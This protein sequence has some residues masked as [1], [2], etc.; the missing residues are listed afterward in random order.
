MATDD[1]GFTAP[2]RDAFFR[3]RG[4]D[5]NM[6][7]VRVPE[8]TT[9]GTAYAQFQKSG[10]GD[11]KFDAQREGQVRDAAT[12]AAQGDSYPTRVLQ[13]VGAGADSLW[14]GT[15]GLAGFGESDDEIKNRRTRDAALADATGGGRFF[16]FLGELLGTMTVPAGMFART[17]QAGAQTVRNLGR[18]ALGGD[19]VPFALSAGRPTTG[20]AV[21]DATLGGGFFGAATPTTS[22]ESRALKAAGGAAGGGA[23]TGLIS[24]AKMIRDA[25][26]AGG[27]EGRAA[28]EIVDLLGEDRAAEVVQKI[29]AEGFGDPR[30]R[31]IP[32]SV[33][34][35]SQD[36]TL[37][38]REKGL[39]ARFPAKA[40]E[41]ATAQR[42]GRWDVLND[43]LDEAGNVL[44]RKA[45]RETATGPLRTAALGK[46]G[47]D[48]WFHQ[49]VA[50][51]LAR[52]R[53]GEAG[54]DPAFRK[55]DAYVTSVLDGGVTPER[56]Y[57]MRK[58]LV[59]GLTEP[60]RPGADDLTAA[61]KASESDVYTLV[62]SIDD[63]LNK[64]SGGKWQ[65]YLDKYVARSGPVDE[66]K[67]QT[68]IKDVFTNDKA[69]VIGGT[70]VVTAH[71][72]GTALENEGSNY[73]GP[74]LSEDT[75]K[76]LRD[77]RARILSAD[78]MPQ[79]IRS[80]GTS[81]MTDPG[82][83]MTTGLMQK[84]LSVLPGIGDIFKRADEYTQISVL[85]ALQ[86]PEVFARS[87]QRK[88]DRNL[89]LKA[90]EV[91]VLQ[92][93]RGASTLG[94]AAALG[95]GATTSAEATQ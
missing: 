45:E 57:R 53:G 40:D 44:P 33:T 76:N 9:E 30:F 50:E 64:A 41:L 23:A 49:P 93:L 77:L 62:K 67:A 20:A 13:N 2:P 79:R 16:Q 69:Q 70:P 51:A 95:G 42:Q 88:L 34:E 17:A 86:H 72:L 12:R 6:Y 27:A 31:G 66:A 18:L 48:Q 84:K 39:N 80:A 61:I 3:F 32:R 25:I 37:A 58:V 35:I 46:A 24:G 89:P 71:K 78:E 65:R 81:G 28:K 59:N 92:L 47:E 85:D 63:A 91:A 10:L 7:K 4:R 73:F 36:P 5:G 82:T 8:G 14:E 15:K 29:Q 54:A 68:A 90:S 22:D 52:L 60:L 11:P 75:L 38:A 56:L 74:M 26:S 55:V 83:A 21:A 94:P 87:V 19:A 1:L 43:M